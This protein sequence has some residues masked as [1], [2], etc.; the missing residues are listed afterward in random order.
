MQNKTQQPLTTADR[1]RI[2]FEEQVSIKGQ[3]TEQQPF[4]AEDRRRIFFTRAN[5]RD[6]R[7]AKGTAPYAIEGASWFDFAAK[8]AR[9]Y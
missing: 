1:R 4:M 8:A 5:S 2:F 9:Q 6:R 3:P 7:A